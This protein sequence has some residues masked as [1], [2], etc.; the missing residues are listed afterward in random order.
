MTDPTPDNDLVRIRS[1]LEKVIHDI[2]SPLAAIVSLADAAAESEDCSKSDD[3][4]A[5]ISNSA[6]A[7]SR[8]ADEQLLLLVDGAALADFE[9]AGCCEHILQS[10]Q[11]M[12]QGQAA[13]KEI[14]LSVQL[15]PGLESLVLPFPYGDV[16]HILGNIVSNAIK[17]TPFG[18]EVRISA[19]R[20]GEAVRFVVTDNGRGMTEAE[21]AFIQQGVR[22]EGE[23]GTG[24]ERGFGLGLYR[25]L[26]TLRQIGGRFEVETAPR[27][28]TSFAI[29]LPL[30]N[31]S[32]SC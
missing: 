1:I 32:A 18:G 29:Y 22:R 16:M 20:N 11:A 9:E 24:G 23:L 4:L 2:R 5:M 15:D 30:A 26:A 14:A 17:F 21:T 12:Y 10:L 13:F 6:R 7:L 27:R 3:Y 31:P 8:Y 28:G 19:V 25:A